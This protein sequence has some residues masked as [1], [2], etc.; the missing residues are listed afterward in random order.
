MNE[1]SYYK[2]NDS[3]RIRC[4]MF[5]IASQYLPN[6]E[7]VETSCEG[8]RDTSSWLCGAFACE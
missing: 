7:C 5:R 4:I 1:R 3:A 2:M 8:K 6:L